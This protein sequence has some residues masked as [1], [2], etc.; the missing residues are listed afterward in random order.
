MESGA[1]AL[2][3]GF[4]LEA[5][6]S[7]SAALERFYEFAL[8]VMCEKKQSLDRHLR[9]NVPEMSR[10]PERQLDA[11]GEVYKPDRCRLSLIADA[12][13]QIPA[14]PIRALGSYLGCVTAVQPSF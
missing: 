6:A 12:P 2:L 1:T 10:Y 3:Q 5:C 13:A 4:T 7:V 8:K 14:S 11:F 9:K